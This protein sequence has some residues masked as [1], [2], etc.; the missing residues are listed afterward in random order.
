MRTACTRARDTRR[1]RASSSLS[2]RL[3]GLQQALD[4]RDELGVVGRDAR[5][6]ALHLRAAAVHEVLVEVPARRLASRLGKLGVKRILLELRLREHRE[7]DR[8]LVDAK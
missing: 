3:V 7:V 6:E 8:V 1:E 4:R 2:P 5:V